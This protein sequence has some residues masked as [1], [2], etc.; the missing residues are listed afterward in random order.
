MAFEEPETGCRFDERESSLRDDE[1]PEPRW[2][3]ECADRLVIDSEADR[4][5][6]L[7]ARRPYVGGSDI[8]ALFGVHGYG[9]DYGSLLDEKLN[10]VVGPD[11]RPY[12]IRRQMER[13]V[14]LDLFAKMYAWTVLPCGWLI[15]DAVCTALATTPDFVMEMPDGHIATMDVKVVRSKPRSECKQMTKSWMPSKEKY[16]DGMPLDLELQLQSQM[17]VLGPRCRYGALLVLHL[18]PDLIPVAYWT[19]RHDGAIRAIRAKASSFI[20]DLKN[21]MDMGIVA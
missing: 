11:T 7:H 17:S 19:P 20:A 14:A 8:A 5:A 6:W 13:F 4:E 15:E 12:Q 10:F 1:T 9:K 3:R 18:I 21:R 16:K 2:M